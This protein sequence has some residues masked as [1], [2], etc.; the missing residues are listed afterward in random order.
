MLVLPVCY[1]DALAAIRRGFED[2]I[3]LGWTQRMSRPVAAEVSGSLGA[4]LASGEDQLPT[5]R[6]NSATVATSIGAAR[7]TFQ[8]LHALRASAGRAVTVEDAAMLHW[9]DVLA[10]GEGLWIEP[11]AAATLATIASLT[12]EGAIQPHHRVVALATAGGLKD[13]D[14]T[15]TRH[16]AVPV[17]PWDD[18]LDAYRPAWRRRSRLGQ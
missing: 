16:I 14:V 13:P 2:M 15:G 9:Q 6:L 3:A 18:P 11:A 7:G 8:A 5:M 10:R 17:L 1:G 12:A 4:A